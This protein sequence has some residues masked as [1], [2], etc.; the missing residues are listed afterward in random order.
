MSEDELLLD[1]ISDAYGGYYVGYEVMSKWEISG[2]VEVRL[3][4]PCGRHTDTFEVTVQKLSS[5]IY[6]K[7]NERISKLEEKLL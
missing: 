5:H 6:N 2:G 3:E 1:C 7:L 4:S